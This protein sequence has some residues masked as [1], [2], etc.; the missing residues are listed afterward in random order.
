M[1]RLC[2]QPF[3]RLALLNFRFKIVATLILLVCVRQSTVTLSPGVTQARHVYTLGFGWDVLSES[4]K[5]THVNTWHIPSYLFLQIL[6]YHRNTNLLLLAIEKETRLWFKLFQL[7][8]SHT[9]SHSW[10]NIPQFNSHIHSGWL[11]GYR[12]V[13]L[14]PVT[15]GVTWMGL[16][17]VVEMWAVRMAGLP[18]STLRSLVNSRYCCWLYC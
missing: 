15:R 1:S 17:D 6:H 9:I 18:P 12:G 3:V 5:I 7:I 8:Q 13:W 10:C 4:R 16:E 14:L 11:R 2:I